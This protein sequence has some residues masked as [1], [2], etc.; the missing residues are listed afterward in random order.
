MDSHVPVV[1]L[2]YWKTSEASTIDYHLSL[3][4]TLSYA[5]FSV[6]ITFPTSIRYQPQK[7]FGHRYTLPLRSLLSFRV[8]ICTELRLIESEPGEKNGRIVR[9]LSRRA[10]P[11]GGRN[12]PGYTLSSLYTI[13]FSW[14][15]SGKNI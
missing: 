2:D 3:E 12:T 4:S 10:I 14:L 1:A 7:N 13:L 5:V 8:R 6:W 9:K 11:S 15:F